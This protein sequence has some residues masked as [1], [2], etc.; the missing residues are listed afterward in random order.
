[1]VAQPDGTH[2]LVDHPTRKGVQYGMQAMEPLSLDVT[3]SAN[4]AEY[5][6]ALIA[7]KAF[8]AL[9]YE[10]CDQMDALPKNGAAA[11]KK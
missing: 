1:M 4:L 11:S 7:M 9:V 2:L 10:L 8:A 6:K 5:Q 3:C